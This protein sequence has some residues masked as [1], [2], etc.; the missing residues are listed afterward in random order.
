MLNLKAF[1]DKYK[2]ELSVI[3]ILLLIPVIEP[4]FEVLVECLFT[5]GKYVGTWIRSISS[6]YLC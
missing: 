2:I 1:I 6:G 4:I 3:L 5:T